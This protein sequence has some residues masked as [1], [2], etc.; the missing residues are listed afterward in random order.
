MSFGAATILP[1]QSEWLVVALLLQGSYSWKIIVLTAS[2]GNILGSVVNW[3][4]GRSFAHY[5]DRAWFPVSVKNMTRAE[6]WY[7]RHGKASLL[8][9]WV[10][11]IGDPLTVVAGLLREPLWSFMGLVGIAKIGRYLAI[12]AVTL[13]WTN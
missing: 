11:I 10:P 12:T 13:S 4:M 6:G 7:R 3:L 9:S 1:L 8:L 2:I 5:Q